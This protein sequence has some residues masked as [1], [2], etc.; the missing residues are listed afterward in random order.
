MAKT[1]TQQIPKGV[2]DALDTI[3]KS[4]KQVQRLPTSGTNCLYQSDAD[5]ERITQQRVTA[6]YATKHQ[7]LRECL[8]CASRIERHYIHT[9]EYYCVY[10]GTRSFH[11]PTSEVDSPVDVCDHKQLTE[12][13]SS[14][15]PH[16]GVSLEDALFYVYENLG[17]DA[18][19]NLKN[20]VFVD[21]FNRTVDLT[22]DYN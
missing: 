21:E 8:D 22:W 5:T 3:N 19:S 6:L 10:F 2:V 14:E 16:T 12:F 9:R 11:I 17:I 18:N 1:R 20:D 7:I 4:A 13:E 15:E